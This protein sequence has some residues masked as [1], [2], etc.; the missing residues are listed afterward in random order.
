FHDIAARFER[1]REDWRSERDRRIRQW[2]AAWIERFTKVQKSKREWINFAEIAEWCSEE[3]GIV[4]SEIA[5]E[6]AYRKLQSDLLEGDFD[7]NGRSQILYLHP[8]SQKVRMTRD[9]LTRLLE[10]KDADQTTINSQYLAHCWMPRDFFERWL[11]KH[12]MPARPQRFEPPAPQS[13]KKARAG[14]KPKWDYE[15]MELFVFREMDR[16]RDFS[17]YRNAEK[18]W[19]SMNDLYVLIKGHFERLT[20]GKSPPDSTLKDHVPPMV[21]KWREQRKIDGN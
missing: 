9:W 5:R 7:K 10:L 14:A 11:A 1:A 13:A 2:R 6:A 8:L 4:A 21:R 3:N 16:R 19:Q 20:D 12:R 17:D 15:E 18:G